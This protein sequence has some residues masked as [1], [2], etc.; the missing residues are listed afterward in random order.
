MPLHPTEPS[1]HRELQAGCLLPINGTQTP[2]LVSVLQVPNDRSHF[3]FIF[4]QKEKLCCL[5]D[6]SLRGAHSQNLLPFII[7][8]LLLITPALIR[9]HTRPKYGVSKR[10]RQQG[11]KNMKE[12]GEIVEL[13]VWGDSQKRVINR[14][15]E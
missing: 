11:G 14:F 3:F 1:G 6:E 10:R 8:I 7:N 5:I 13:C 15:W 2:P 4:N 9:S 12:K